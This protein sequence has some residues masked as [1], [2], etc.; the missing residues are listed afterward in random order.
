MIWALSALVASVST[1]TAATAEADAEP[2][3]LDL[4]DVAIDVSFVNVPLDGDALD[5]LDD[6]DDSHGIDPAEMPPVAPMIPT[7]C[8][9][10]MDFL[11]SDP[12]F[13]IFRTAVEETGMDSVFGNIR[14]LAT[15]LLPTNDAIKKTFAERK[16][17][18]PD[19]VLT[20]YIELERLVRNH[21]LPMYNI[22][23]DDFAEVRGCLDTMVEGTCLLVSPGDDG[24]VRLGR[25]AS[26]RIDKDMHDLGKDYCPTTI[27]AVDGLLLV[28]E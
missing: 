25:D 13:S 22:R 18:S 1:A 21:V 3:H 15:V 2:A 5:D 17:L 4:T 28:D 14:L 27:H 26:V 16:N 12:R 20:D 11:S 24:E 8:S 9:P 23:Y 19:H 10:V 7:G 6:P